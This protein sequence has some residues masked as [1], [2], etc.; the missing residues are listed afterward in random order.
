MRAC[1]LSLLLE[2]QNP[3]CIC[4]QE[5]K[6]SNNNVPY[7]INKYYKTYIKLPDNN[8]V[9]KGG[10]LIAIKNIIPHNQIPLNTDL[11]AVAVSFPSGELRSICSVYLPPNDPVTEDDLRN[12]TNQ[13]PKP[14][15]IVG[16]LNAHN[17]LWYDRN[18]DNRGEIIQNIIETENLL[19]LNEDTP[20]FF[21]T[22]DQATSNIDL[23]L[24]SRV[25]QGEFIWSAL[26]DLNGSDH[27]PIV[28]TAH[29]TPP[30][31][32]VE[33]WNLKEA[34]WNAFKDL[35]LTT[36]RV[37]T[38]P[39]IED[40]YCHL[41]ETIINAATSSIPRTQINKNKRPNVPWW[42]PKCKIER[43]NVR[44]AFKKMKRNPN[45]VT[46]RTYRRRLAI[47][48]R[49][50]RQAKRTSWKE[51]VTQLKPKTP[52][53]I[54]WK[55]IRKIEGKYI[56]KPHPILK[57]GQEMKT[58]HK[59]VA[60]IF[61]DYYASISTSRKPNQ[62][63]KSRDQSQ[64][65]NDAEI[66]LK[67]GMRELDES[68]KQLEEGKST[69]Q[70]QIDN[71]M[72]KHLPP[73]TKQYLL[74]LY[75]KLWCEGSFPNEW[76]SSIILPILKPG[77]DST[78]PKNYRPISLTS[79]ICKLLER[80]VNNRLMWFLEKTQK[81]SPQQYG[82]RQGRNTIDPIAAI[83][84]DILN[85][86]KQNKTTTA[87]FFDFEKAFDTIDRQTITTNLD[88]M[89]IHG[90]MLKF[91]ENYLKERLIK[92]KIGNTLSEDRATQA[93][94]PQGGVLS[95]TCFLVAINSIFDSIPRDVKASLYADDLVIYRTSKNI[96][97]SSRVLQNTIKKLEEW[98]KN[99]GLRFSPTKSEV[100]HFWRGIK[101]GSNREYTPLKLYQSEIP[102]KETARFLGM[103]LDRKLSWLPHI[104]SLKAEALRSLNILKVVSRVNYGPERKT[105]LQLY[106]AICKSK[107]DYG[108][109]IY[110]SA[111]TDALDKLNTVH[112]EA[113]R[114]CT[115][116]FRSSPEKSLQVEAGSPPLDLQ[117]DEQVLRYIIRLESSP[118][119]L[120]KLNVLEDEYDNMYEEDKQQQVPIGTR[121]RH[122]KQ[123][124]DFAPNPILNSE[125]ETPLWLLNKINIC[126]EGTIMLKR[127]TTPSRLQQDFLSH[128]NKHSS[129]KHIYTD[130][131]K[132]QN[133]VGFGVVYGQN[134]DR[135]VRG[136]LPKETTVFA[137]EVQ[138]I[139]RA[140]TIIEESVHLN[141]TIFTDSQ[142]SLQAITQLNPKHPLIKVIQTKLIQLQLEQKKICFCKIPSH[143]GIKGNE[144]ADRVANESLALPG[145][146]TTQ[147]Y[148]RD[149]HFPIRRKIME[150]WQA[151][152]EQQTRNKLRQSKPNVKPWPN[153]PG[154]SRRIEAKITRLRIGHTRLTHGHYMSRGRPPEC[155]YCGVSPLTTKH[156]LTECQ[157]TLPIRQRLKLPSDLQ[158][159]LGEHC[160]VTPLINYLTELGILEDI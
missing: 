110:S 27:Y 86:F 47:K 10:S 139:S 8:L 12:L 68:L 30:P 121:A 135:H 7:N 45:S 58:S 114:L 143:V 93:G 76:K 16:D 36:R 28:I 13:L 32:L 98:A 78:N 120:E 74:D 107:I 46:T 29:H 99:V 136:T 15:M 133:G 14:T 159:L 25:C 35:A 31:D 54:I 97:T 94:V 126:R 119:Y 127:N 92:V 9:P 63:T 44:S 103:I 72:L 84:T 102:H 91:I 154:G 151:R 1:E 142:S 23:A 134:Q 81:L 95:A 51:Y 157:S 116:A 96:Q 71:A 62:P 146:Y 112:N 88:L 22:H 118:K 125:T 55:K 100:V 49:T 67:F 158:K 124:L 87:V 117:R 85:G 79:C 141:W 150:I 2:E 61:V 90:K 59:D 108:S 147:V 3:S 38:I 115:G 18:L 148:H 138:A 105:L 5:L 50:Y 6:L 89:G 64:P 152:W 39:D 66:N 69:G 131:S 77:K 4:L 82:F 160:P 109:Q 140:L 60:N 34:D 137:A 104:Q 52:T 11:Q 53:S 73:V 111:G 130:G 122:L 83:T 132:S 40:A 20:T 145:F 65:N 33:K 17:P 43:T 42:T 128:M 123:H 41:K 113:L 26:D 24:I 144:A 70:D 21:R 80:M 153:I 19:I 75:N 156:F 155:T 37:E 57:M 129:S 149:Y 56:P 106:W 101:G 48:V